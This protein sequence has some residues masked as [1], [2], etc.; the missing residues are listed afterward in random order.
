[1]LQIGLGVKEQRGGLENEDLGRSQIT[2][3]F[4]YQVK[5]PG[6]DSIGNR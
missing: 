5:E 4:E 6:L 3:T 2:K 1:M